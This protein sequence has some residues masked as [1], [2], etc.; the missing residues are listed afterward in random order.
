MDK[1]EGETEKIIIER[2]E[3]FFSFIKKN[4]NLIFYILLIIIIIYGGIYLRTLNV[5]QLKDVTTGNWTLAPDLDPFLFLRWAKEIAEHGSLAKIDNLRYVPLGFDTTRELTLTSYFIFYLYKIIKLFSPNATIEYAAIIYPIIF[6]CLT[7]IAAF[8]FVG[9]IFSK[10][11]NANLIALI[12]VLFI[13]VIPGFIHRTVAGVPEK[14]S[15]G[16]FFMFLAFYFIAST[17][18]EEKTKKAILFGLL[19]GVSTALMGLV[20]GGVTF[21]FLTIALAT[22]LMFFFSKFEKKDVLV[23]TCWIIGFTILLIWFPRYGI[24]LF[25]SITSGF[26]YFVF[27]LLILDSIIFSTNLK[28]KLKL[29]KVKVPKIFSF[30]AFVII[31]FIFILIFEPSFI[32]HLITDASDYIFRPFA[33]NRFTL[34]VA[35]NNRPFFDSWKN[36]FGIPF[37]WIFVLGSVFL[38]Y[39]LFEKLKLKDRILLTGIYFLMIVGMIFSRY[40]EN[41]IMNGSSIQSFIAFLGSIALFVITILAIYFRKKEMDLDKNILLLLAIL[42]FAIFSARAAIRLFYFIYPIAPIMAAFAIV[43]ISEIALKTKEDIEKIILLIIAGGI[44]ILSLVA[45]YNFAQASEVEVKYATVPGH[46]QIQWQKAMAWVRENTPKDAVFSHWW[47]YGY[48]VQSIGERA[49]IL[50]GGNAIT[51]WDHL[52]GRHVLTAEN[53]TEALEFLKTHK[54][55]YL[56]ID[57]TDI[58]KYPAYS[59]IGADENYDRYSWISTFILDENAIQE[60]RNE[61]IYVFKGGAL[62][63][64][65]IIWK[66]H[67]YP[68]GEAGIG[69]I[70]LPIKKLKD[71]NSDY[72][73]GKFG[74]PSI[75]LIYQNKQINIPFKCIY[76]EGSKIEFDEGIDGCFYIIPSISQNKVIKLGAGFWLSKKLLNSL[77]VKVYLLNETENFVLEH[78]ENDPIINEINLNYNLNLPELVFHSSAGLLGPIKIWKINYPEL[79][80]ENSAY[81]EIVYPKKELWE[82]KR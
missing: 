48:W 24:N 27:G 46:Y 63:D 56:L 4:Q 25:T 77:M 78:T 8:L 21:L 55:N 12:S 15:A 47:D 13:S 37:F 68:E 9:K 38:I 51:Y 49:T 62:L 50:D 70:L 10:Y 54:A 66:D 42:F 5:S 3:K 19:A 39:E 36:S 35:E 82:V 7:L 14:E 67:I 34:T 29:E 26:A 61:T 20:W 40:S 28:I 65:D 33:T 17:F 30:I 80:Q 18:K 76:L 58:G 57:S 81:L 64:K 59:S 44:I 52:L 45:L 41:S 73:I 31:I 1:G 75:V 16:I 6:F 74:Q 71:N 32:S 72:V 53:E 11:K 23:Y 22:F 2:K 60:K 43:R 79:I 69:A